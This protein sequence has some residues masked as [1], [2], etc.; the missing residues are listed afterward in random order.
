MTVFSWYFAMAWMFAWATGMR[1]HSHFIWK[2]RKLCQIPLECLCVAC[3]STFIHMLGNDVDFVSK[4]HRKCVFGF[5][6]PYQWQA[7]I[8]SESVM[9]WPFPFWV[10][11]F[12]TRNDVNHKIVEKQHH[13]PKGNWI[14]SFFFFLILKHWHRNHL[15]HWRSALFLQH[16]ITKLVGFFPMHI[17]CEDVCMCGHGIILRVIHFI[18]IYWM[19]DC[20]HLDGNGFR[21][22]FIWIQ[23]QCVQSQ[24]PIDSNRNNSKCQAL[25]WAV[26]GACIS[27]TSFFEWRYFQE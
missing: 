14:C 23:S 25:V 7:T 10:A 26:T 12:M 1:I 22:K 19:P 9:C 8:E 21:K 20:F 4:V 2:E 15:K 27:F 17:E 24:I 13:Q 5:L 18:F 3:G 16:K 11:F 6:L